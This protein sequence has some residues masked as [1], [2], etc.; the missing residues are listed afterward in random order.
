LRKGLEI[1]IMRG[2]AIGKVWTKKRVAWLLVENDYQW[3]IMARRYGSS[4]CL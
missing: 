4:I 3:I 2:R 1:G